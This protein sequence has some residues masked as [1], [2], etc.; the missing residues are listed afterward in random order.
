MKEK[1][2]IFHL[3]IVI[4][5][6]LNAQL[7]NEL[8]TSPHKNQKKQVQKNSSKLYFLVTESFP[9]EARERKFLTNNFIESTIIDFED[10]IF[11]R[12]KYQGKI[13]C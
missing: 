7:S 5:F 10:E 4:G 9:L 13:L 2:L 3:I 6:N 1:F 12:N 8:V 11:Y